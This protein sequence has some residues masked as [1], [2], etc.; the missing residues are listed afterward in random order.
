MK[1]TPKLN[2]IK[3]YL[4]TA[5]IA[6]ADVVPR[7]NAVHDGMFNNPDYPTPPVDIAAFKTTIDAYTTSIAAAIDGGKAALAARDKRRNEAIMMY[8]LLGHYVE[9]ASKNDMTTFVS[10]GFVAVPP[11]QRPSTQPVSSPIIVS[12][13]QGPSGQLLVMVKAVKDARSYSIRFAP[14]PA[15]GVAANW[16][17]V[18]A[19]TVKPAVPLTGLVPG[20]IYMI[21]AQALGKLGLSDWG[22]PVQ[23]MCI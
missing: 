20:T 16:T 8:R 9:M 19:A 6:D 22:S 17:T 2:L 3:P 13:T 14:V 15:P 18:P 1:K 11:P 12:V 7:L 5:G 4:T 10:S 23:R 21:Q